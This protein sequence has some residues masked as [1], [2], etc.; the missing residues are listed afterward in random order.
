VIEGTNAGFK[1]PRSASRLR[2]WNL[3]FLSDLD[4]VRVF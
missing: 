4:V 2:G 1:S 3:Q